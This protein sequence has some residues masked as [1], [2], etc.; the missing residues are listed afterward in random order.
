MTIRCASRKSIYLDS[1]VTPQNDTYEKFRN[2][3]LNNVRNITTIPQPLSSWG[4]TP[5]SRSVMSRANASTNIAL[6]SLRIA[7]WKC[8]H[9]GASRHPGY[10][11]GNLNCDGNVAS[12]PPVEESRVAGRWSFIFCPC[13]A[14]APGLVTTHEIYQFRGW[15]PGEGEFSPRRQKNKCA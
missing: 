4:L 15:F 10:P 1:G 2:T 12:S 14:M 11:E 3:D 7:L 8:R 13:G 9:P 6:C 5:G